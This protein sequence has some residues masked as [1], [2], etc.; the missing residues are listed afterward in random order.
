MT[1]AEVLS[2]DFENS[3]IAAALRGELS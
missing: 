1:I 3:G 2:R